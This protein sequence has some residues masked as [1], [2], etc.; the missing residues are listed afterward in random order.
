MVFE[1]LPTQTMLWF[2]EQQCWGGRLP[3]H[4]P[5]PGSSGQHRVPLCARL[6]GQPGLAAAPKQRQPEYVLLA[7]APSLPQLSLSVE[8]E[9]P[10]EEQETEE[11]PHDCP[12]CDPAHWVASHLPAGSAASG[13]FHFAT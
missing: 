7:E 3:G 11:Q 10:S 6:E 5:L 2:Y 12:C 1:V 4:A 8:E 9:D 13:H